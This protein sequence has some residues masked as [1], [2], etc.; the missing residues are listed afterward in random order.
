MLQC[1]QNDVLNSLYGMNTVFK[2]MS[3]FT[4]WTPDKVVYS[5]YDSNNDEYNIFSVN[6]CNCLGTMSG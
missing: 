3:Q 2:N 1:S 4:S 5:S 6:I